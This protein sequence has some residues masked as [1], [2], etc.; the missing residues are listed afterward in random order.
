MLVRDEICTVVQ[1][2]L[3]NDQPLR[4]QIT[5]IVHDVLHD[6][7]I[8]DKIGEVVGGCLS[9]DAVA[10]GIVSAIKGTSLNALISLSEKAMSFVPAWVLVRTRPLI[11]GT[12]SEEGEQ[13]PQEPL[14][15][16]DIT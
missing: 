4:G 6:G 7:G 9:N 12:A 13:A 16:A 14:R 1:T 10:H 2:V 3:S 8:E 15:E 11:Q 5:N